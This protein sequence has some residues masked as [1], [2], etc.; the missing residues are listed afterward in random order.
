MDNS[1]LDPLA[2]QSDSKIVFLILDGISGLKVDG[3]P[4]TEMQ[5]ANLPNLDRLAKESICGLLD[6]ILPG[7]TPGSGPAHFALFG[8]DPI[9]FNMGRGVLSAS[10]VGFELTDRDLAARINFCTVDGSGNVTDRRAGR[11]A[12]GIG[13]RLCDKIESAVVVPAGYEFNFLPEKEHRAVMILRG[14]GLNDSVQDTDSQQT[15]VPPLEPEALSPEADFTSG[16]LKD[17][18]SQI[19]GILADESPANMVLL[20]GFAKHKKYPSMME[21]FKLKSLAIANYP[22]YRGISRLIGM[23]LNPVTPSIQTQIDALENKFNEYDYFFIHIKYT[24]ACGEDGDFDGKVKVLEEV[25]ELIPRIVELNPDV[26]VVT[27]DHST[28]S[29]MSTHSWHPVPVLINSNLARIDPVEHF[30]EISCIQGG[31]GRQPSVHL[32]GL[33]LAHANR[34]QKFGA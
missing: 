2:I 23:D 28:P 5:V 4:G 31:I 30:D 10:G 15:G 7:V 24:D 12:S 18:I 6:P 22:M 29:K 17:I 13:V 8:Y 11:I 34:L 20:R 14:D 3:K 32:M 1:I 26:L 16:L 27:G 9:E 33:V 21:R 19:R 25:D